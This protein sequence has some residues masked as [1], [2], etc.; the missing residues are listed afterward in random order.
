MSFFM[1]FYKSTLCLL[2]FLM[3]LCACTQS[4]PSVESQSSI[5]S[6]SAT[7]SDFIARSDSAGIEGNYIP[8]NNEKV[9]TGHGQ[10]IGEI[11]VDWDKPLYQDEAGADVMGISG[12]TFTS[13]SG[14]DS[15]RMTVQ[16]LSET[17]SEADENQRAI[18]TK[19]FLRSY[20]KNL[21]MINIPFEE[22]SF[23]GFDAI[24]YTISEPERSAKSLLFIYGNNS[25]TLQVTANS[26]VEKKFHRFSGAVNF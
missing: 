24:Q 5:D 11:F 26:Q 7:S 19:G 14:S 9:K 25:Y 17:M 21:S 6:M 2:F 15:Y 13:K 3:A 8:E 18:F 4:D 1:V 12:N 16:D 23:N 20:M 22:I 10:Q